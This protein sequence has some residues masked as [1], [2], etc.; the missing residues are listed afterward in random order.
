MVWIYSLKVVLIWG[1]PYP[2]IINRLFRLPST[3]VANIWLVHT[4][5]LHKIVHKIYLYAEYVPRAKNMNRDYLN[6]YTNQIYVQKFI[7]FAPTIAS[8][9]VLHTGKRF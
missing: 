8:T 5:I 1:N 2:N 6:K 9:S 3:L 4:I 7:V